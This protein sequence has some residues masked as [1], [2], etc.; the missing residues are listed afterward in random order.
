[1][2]V[3]ELAGV[4]AMM[5]LAEEF[6]EQVSLGLVVPVS[7]SAASVEVAAGSRGDTQRG[8]GPDR[9]DSIQAPVFDMTLQDNGFLAAGPGDRRRPGERFESAGIGETGT[10]ITDLGEHPGTGELTQ[11]GKD[12]SW[13]E[14]SSRYR[15]WRAESVGFVVELVG[16]QA[17]M[18]LSE[19]LVEQ[20]PL[21]LGVTVPVVSA[22][23]VMRVGSRRRPQRA[24]GPQ[25][26]GM[27]ES[28]IFDVAVS[29]DTGQ[30]HR[31]PVP[32]RADE[33]VTVQRLRR[34]RSQRIL[35]GS[36]QTRRGHPVDGLPQPVGRGMGVDLRRTDGSMAEKVLDLVQRAA[37]VEH[38]AGER[39]TQRVRCHSPIDSRQTAQR[40]E[41]VVDARPA[42]LVR[43]PAAGTG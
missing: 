39:M 23:P 12:I 35:P 30:R 31:L 38:I 32:S 43:R 7:G 34:G 1:M 42:S 15:E 36:L 16:V 40:D 24:Q 13:S 11:P 6:V 19:E 4:Q 37:G 10:V 29:D 28:L 21:R 3:I 17:V 5:Q 25:E 8:Q 20:V 18:Q 14:E 9:T 26:P 41:Q 22:S 2:F 27:G 33:K